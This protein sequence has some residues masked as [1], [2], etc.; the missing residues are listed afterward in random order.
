M[1]Y[2]IPALTIIT[3]HGRNVKY[4]TKKIQITEYNIYDI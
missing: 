3:V 4:F 2:G 1:V